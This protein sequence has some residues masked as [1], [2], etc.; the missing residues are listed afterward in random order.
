MVAARRATLGPASSRARRIAKPIWTTRQGS[1][2]FWPV[3]VGEINLDALARDRDQL[4]AE[5]LAA[6]EAAEPW[7][8]QRDVE[9]ALFAPEQQ[10]RQKDPDPWTEA[11]EK[12][13]EEKFE[14]N[15][16]ASFSTS[17][18]LSEAILMS[19]ERMNK[20]AQMR[21][22]EIFKRLKLERCGATS[23]RRWRR[24]S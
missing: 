19:P 10:R 17:D 2:R 8:P 11:V 23:R 9:K 7:W 16:D 24:P 12:W 21:I 15:R 18:A 20:Y 22:A 13:I 5:A 3:K 1:G 14:K 4:F 6:Y